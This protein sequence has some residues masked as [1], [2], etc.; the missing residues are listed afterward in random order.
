M[1][2]GSDCVLELS[3]LYLSEN[4]SCDI[5]VCYIYRVFYRPDCSEAV[6]A[7]IYL[8]CMLKRGIRLLKNF[9]LSLNVACLLTVIKKRGKIA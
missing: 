1:E 9:L 6:S 8:I 7:V 4:Y 2:W 3:Y 5:Y